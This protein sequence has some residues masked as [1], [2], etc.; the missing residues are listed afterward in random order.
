MPTSAEEASFH[1]P[2]LTPPRPLPPGSGWIGAGQWTGQRAP[3]PLL[4]AL[5]CWANVIWVSTQLL[6]DG[7][8]STFRI[9]RAEKL[10]HCGVTSTFLLLDV[11]AGPWDQGPGGPR[12]LSPFSWCYSWPRNP[13]EH[14]SFLQICLTSSEKALGPHPGAARHSFVPFIIALFKNTFLFISAESFSSSSS[15]S[16]SR[17]SREPEGALSQILGSS[18]PV[19]FQ[20]SDS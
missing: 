11:G 5:P 8:H 19:L 20:M 2:S 3:W 17:H 12:R 7:T 4:V 18:G 1:L 16:S 13:G 10:L 15:S 9:S 14:C 6:C